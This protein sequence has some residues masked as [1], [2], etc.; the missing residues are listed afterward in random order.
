MGKPLVNMVGDRYGLLTVMSRAENYRG[1]AQWLC[2]CDCGKLRTYIGF[3]LRKGKLRSCGCQ[4]PGSQGDHGMSKTGTYQSWV[5]MRQRCNNP[6]AKVYAHYGARGIAVCERWNDSFPNFLADLGP[7][8]EGCSLERIDNNGN[9]EPGNCRWAT[10][11]DQMNNRRANRFIEL[12]GKRQTLAQWL[13]EVGMTNE[14]FFD[15]TKRGWSEER[16]LTT[17]VRP[18]THKQPKH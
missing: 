12:N 9:Y 11:R 5:S 18:F 10:Q 8:P 3:D 16:A 7:R 1:N 14:R 15:R 6:R 17:P 13:R 2:K 4:N